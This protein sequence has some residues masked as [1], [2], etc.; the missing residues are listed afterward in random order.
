L[1]NSAIKLV[2]LF[3]PHVRQQ[4]IHL[5]SLTTTT[6]PVK[7]LSFKGDKKTKKRKH[8]DHESDA[9]PNAT[10]PDNAP[11]SDESWTT[12]DAATD[13]SGPTLIVLPT[14]P[15]TCLASD[16]NG[17][18]FASPIENLVEGHAETA[19]PHDVRQV[20]VANQI[21]GTGQLSFKASHGGFLSCDGMGILGARR[22]ARGYE[23]GFVAALVQ[24]DE[25]KLRWTLKTAASKTGAEGADGG[26]RYLAAVMDSQAETEAGVVDVE[27]QQRSK[28]KMKVAIS[29]RGD[30]EV[31]APEAELVLKM[32]ARFKPRVQLDKESK[33]NEKISRKELEHVVGRRLEDDEVKRLKR[34][35]KNGTYHEE[36]L[37]VRV[38]GKH[39]KFA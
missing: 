19:E 27:E 10:D 6:M 26:P 7:P 22:E 30:A 39:D 15:P 18:V 23:E 3:V 21:A 34:A 9:T 32:Q 17:N 14:Q 4:T 36:I 8:R 37:D 20:W 2:R 38:K 5:S 33:A 11:V 1:W 35:R 13:L 12:P 16:A 24:N 25:G 28:K 29:L 31:G